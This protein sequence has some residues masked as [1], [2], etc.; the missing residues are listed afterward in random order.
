MG[1]LAKLIQK[2]Q[3]TDGRCIPVRRPGRIWIPE[4]RRSKD[5]V[6]SYAAE[7]INQVCRGERPWP[8][9]LTG[10]TGSGKTCA[11]LLIVDFYG[12]LYYTVTDWVRR[13]R[14]AELGR[15]T[16]EAGYP[17]SA[18]ESWDDWIN[19]PVCVL[20]ELGVRN[21]V[22]D[23]RYETVKRSI[24]LRENKPL[25]VVSNLAIPTIGKLYD[26]RIASRLQFGTEIVFDT[27]RRYSAVTE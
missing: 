12:G 26:E 19:A 10:E 17:L 18:K 7:A 21:E 9:V 25:V 5:E 23:H 13:V 2:A 1:E 27:D 11:A 24:D 14:D 15:L 4:K 6:L 3:D 16:T 22:S 20:D 8:L